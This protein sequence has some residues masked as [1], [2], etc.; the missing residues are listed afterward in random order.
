MWLAGW[1]AAF[2]YLEISWLRS[3][4]LAHPDPRTELA[5]VEAEEEVACRPVT[6]EGGEEEG[7]GKGSSAR[8]RGGRKGKGKGGGAR[9]LLLV[10]LLVGLV[11][12]PRGEPPRSRCLS[13]STDPSSPPHA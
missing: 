4:M 5:L 1:K 3:H 2:S 6:Q 9:P 11:L 12:R 13:A 8:R 10:V 7:E